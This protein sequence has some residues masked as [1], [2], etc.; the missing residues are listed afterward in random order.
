M[1]TRRKALLAM[2]TTLL[3]VGFSYVVMVGVFVLHF[4]DNAACFDA[5]DYEACE[6]RASGNLVLYM[7]GGIAAWSGG[8]WLTL[9][10]WGVGACSR[11]S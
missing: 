8:L 4:G 9:K 10:L 3:F 1:G 2:L 11:K 7:I 5:A 6:G